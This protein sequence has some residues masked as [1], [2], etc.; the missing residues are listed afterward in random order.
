MS[1]FLGETIKVRIYEFQKITISVKKIMLFGK[2]QIYG[3]I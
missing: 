1:G 3:C 2:K